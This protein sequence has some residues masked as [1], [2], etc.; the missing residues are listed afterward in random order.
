MPCAVFVWT[1]ENDSGEDKSVS[2]TFTFQNGVGEG[3]D[4]AGGCWSEHFHTAPSETERGSQ[5]V[6]IHHSVG[7]MGYT[8]AIA[9]AE[10]VR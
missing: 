3:S 1:V 6:L 10:K 5:G 7:D 9:A 8:F 2:I 4:K